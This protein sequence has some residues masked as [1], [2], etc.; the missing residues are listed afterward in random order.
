MTAGIWE[1]FERRFAVRALECYGA[2]EGGFAVTPVR[3]GPVGS[4]GKPP[5]TLEM[6]VVDEEGRERHR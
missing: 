2:M 5:P 1:A 6:K 4:F 3:V